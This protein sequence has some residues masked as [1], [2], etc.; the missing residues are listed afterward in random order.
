MP[1]LQI[2]ATR[3]RAVVATA[4]AVLRPLAWIRP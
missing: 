3:E 4:D 1:R 2:H